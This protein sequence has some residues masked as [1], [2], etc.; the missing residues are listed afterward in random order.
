MSEYDVSK[1]NGVNINNIEYSSKKQE[2]DEIPEDL[3]KNDNLCEYTYDE[4]DKKLEKKKK[5]L[6]GGLL[7][8]WN[9]GKDI[10]KTKDGTTIKVSK[11]DKDANIFIDSQSGTL[12]I[13]NADNITIKSKNNES[14]AMVNSSASKINFGKYAKNKEFDFFSGFVSTVSPEEIVG[15]VYTPE[16]NSTNNSIYNSVDN[17]EKTDLK[18]TIKQNYP[19]IVQE[20]NSYTSKELSSELLR[21]CSIENLSDEEKAK[22][23]YIFALTADGMISN[24]KNT[25]EEL[26]YNLYDKIEEVCKSDTVNGDKYGN[27][28]SSEEV[29]EPEMLVAMIFNES[30]GNYNAAS[31][32][33]AVGFAGIMSVAEQDVNEYYG[34][35]L[36][37]TLGRKL[38]RNNPED[39][40]YLGAMCYKRN[41][42]I[43]ET[44]R[45]GSVE[46]TKELVVAAY[47]SG[48]GTVKKAGFEIPN[49]QETQNHVKKVMGLYE[50]LKEY[51]EYVEQMK[52]MY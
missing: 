23:D 7:S 40:I 19:N 27:V 38:N 21:L 51:P 24:F 41:Q 34:Y 36:T 9:W 42:M 20:V 39:N 22:K 4:S 8:F 5:S 43:L 2:E 37:K 15:P 12:V 10:Y 46:I 47:N 13:E 14:I 31:K 30:S 1:I 28:T 49:I 16:D 6:F 52:D 18:T 33:G 50:F 26:G 45:K 29:I 44:Y 32:S 3:F 48:S 11:K 35:N 25:S 17:V